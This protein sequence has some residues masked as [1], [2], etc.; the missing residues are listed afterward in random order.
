M[1]NNIKDMKEIWKDIEGYNGDYQIS[2]LGRVISFKCGKIRYLKHGVDSKGYYHI[3][4]SNNGKI[5]DVRIHQLVWDNFG[6]SKRNGH[7]LQVD[8]IDNNKLNN[9]IDNL[10]L[11]SQ[12]ENVSKHYLRTDKSSK[13]TGVYWYKRGKKWMSRIKNNGKQNYLG[14]FDS[15]EEANLAYQKALNEL[16]GSNKK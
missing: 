5:K 9:R 10:Q 13:Y 7:I 4:L 14:C 1:G 15:E 16:T 2:N 11:L 3:V 6:D 8:H 12:R